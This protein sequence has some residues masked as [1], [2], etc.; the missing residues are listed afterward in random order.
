MNV[1]RKIITPTGKLEL[2][3]KPYI[4]LTLIIYVMQ[5]T[6]AAIVPF[7]WAVAPLLM[8]TYLHVNINAQRARDSGIK[9]R[10]IVLLSI[11]VYILSTILIF[12]FGDDCQSVGI[13]IN[14]GFDLSLCLIL[15]I[16][17][18][19]NINQTVKEKI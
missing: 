7:P 15:A 14:L 17:P 8:F 4:I 16:A 2:T 3:Q 19:K 18:S 13:K 6:T 10:Y 1:I 9:G 12:F 5:I 11:A